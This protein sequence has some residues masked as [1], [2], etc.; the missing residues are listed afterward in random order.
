MGQTILNCCVPLNYEILSY[1]N[2]KSHIYLPY[3][4]NNNILNH[5]D[6]I[7]KKK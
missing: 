3:K 1:I 5:K 4:K 6:L 2:H 7:D